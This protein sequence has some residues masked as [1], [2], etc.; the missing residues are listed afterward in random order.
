MDHSI[1]VVG[2]E[3][4][5]TGIVT[6]GSLVSFIGFLLLLY[7]AT[8]TSGRTIGIALGAMILLIVTYGL[9]QDAHRG[10]VLP[11]VDIPVDAMA[12]VGPTNFPKTTNQQ[13]WNQITRARI[14]LG[15]EE[16]RV[17]KIAAAIEEPKEQNSEV[18]DAN[19]ETTEEIEEA[20]KTTS[21]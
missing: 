7:F 6:I 17:T 20:T 5:N 13:L 2:G 15:E 9:L 11:G 14:E 12:A 8:K 19:S 4:L 16:K 21:P 18:E 10:H 1:T 3:S